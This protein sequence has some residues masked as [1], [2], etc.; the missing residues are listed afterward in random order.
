MAFM[1]EIFHFK[2]MFRD[3]EKAT[4][5]ALTWMVASNLIKPKKPKYKKRQ[6]HC[7]T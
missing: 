2:K 1:N 6:L 7:L 4:K 3:I 5:S